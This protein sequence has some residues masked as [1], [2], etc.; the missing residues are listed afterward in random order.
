MSGADSQRG[1]ASVEQTGL[2]LIVALLML[3]GIGA[4]AAHGPLDGGRQLASVIARRMTCAPHLPEPCRRDRLVPAYGWDLARLVRAQAPDPAMLTRGGLVPV[5]FRRC[6]QPSCAIPDHGRDPS[7][8]TTSNRRITAFTEVRESGRGAARQVEITYWLYRPGQGWDSIH[9]FA[10]PAEID[11]ARATELGRDESPILIPLAT[12]AGRNH[13]P[14]RRTEEPPWR[15]RVP[16][17]YP[18]RPQ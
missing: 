4:V 9:E 14:F 11:A 10:G 15:W 12:L 17:I 1:S 18:G 8:L 13:I 6:R 5:D 16:G 3:V 7:R 2:I